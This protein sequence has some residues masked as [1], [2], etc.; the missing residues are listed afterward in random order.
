MTDAYVSEGFIKRDNLYLASLQAMVDVAAAL[1]ES[2][3]M[4]AGQVE[5]KH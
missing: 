4:I 1:Q 5:P 3:R 2:N